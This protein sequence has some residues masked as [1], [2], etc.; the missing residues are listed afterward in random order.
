[1]GTLFY[2]AGP[3][4]F[5]PILNYGR[6]TNNVRAEDAKF[7]E[8]LVDYQNTVLRAQQEVEDAAAGFL[9]SQESVVFEQNAVTAAQQAV[10]LA[11]IQYREGAV[12]YQRV[13]DA[14]RALFLEQNNLARLRSSVVTNLIALYKALG[15][16]WELRQGEPAIPKSTQDEMR[17]RTNWGDFFS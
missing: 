6:I 7:Q 1:P 4:I 12:D 9:R 5:W 10:K 15:G 2:N 3:N 13:V 11:F 8:S 17:D 14:E 16:G